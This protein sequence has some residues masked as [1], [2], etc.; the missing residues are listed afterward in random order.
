MSP[1]NTRK[2]KSDQ[3]EESS[4]AVTPTGSPASK[5]MRITEAQKQALI[6]N[7]QLEITERARQLRAG[8]A[9]QC[10][11]L[12]ARIER[13]VNRIP[14]AIR[15]MT[16]GELMEKH[17]VPKQTQS[18]TQSKP[19]R[20]PQTQS[21][22]SK[23]RPLP[24]LPPQQPSKAHS[25]ARPQ[26]Q[27]AAARGKKR[28]SSEIHIASD[29][30]NDAT[31][32]PDTLPVAKNNKRAKTAA[33]ASGPTKQPSVLSPR[34]H[35]SRTLPRSPI[36]EYPMAPSSPAKSMIARPTSPL[37]PASP[38]KT[39][40]TAATSAI[41]ASMHGMIEHAKRST[42]AKLTRTA[43]KEKPVTTR[44]HMLPPPRPL[45]G[46]PSSPQRTVSQTSTHSVST[47]VSTASS[48]TTLIKA[49]RGRAATT[50]TAES[51][52]P[53][54]TAKRGVAKAA[55]AAKT[56]LKRNATTANKKVVVAEPA[57]GKRVLRKRT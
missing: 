39:A 1:T 49:K 24:P 6:D 45:P 32:A 19:I 16:M 17:E 55:S 54:A 9:L 52:S 42:T 5:K 14:L 56:A 13:R 2:R 4:C 27:S 3:M 35:N 57:A 10:A 43:S 29:K 20:Q 15:K 12:R 47:D 37:K 50:K 40:A 30:E 18:K 22:A 23:E 46:A 7:L 11:D 28:K 51:K 53:G 33:T 21:A 44:G 41:S 26:P 34:S 8:Y 38:F 36:K 31:G 25:P 48:G